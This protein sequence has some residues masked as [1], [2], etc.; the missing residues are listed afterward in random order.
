M[1]KTTSLVASALLVGSSALANAAGF[2]LIE[3]N[4][5]GLGNAYAGA[6][7]VAEDASTVF[8]NPAGM[9]YLPDSQLVIAGHAIRPS[10]EF[11]NGG[12]RTL[13][14]TPFVQPL[15]GG[16][17]GD[18]GSWALVPN[19]YYVHAITP[20]I[21]AG[22]GV[23]AP[24]GLK[25]DY[26]GNWVGRYDAVKS[27]LKTVNIN[28][29]LAWR[30][31]D[32][33]SVGG[34]IDVRYIDVELTSAVD[35]GSACA[36]LSGAIPLLAGCAA[37]QGG[38][39][40]L[41]L[42]GD[43]WGWGYNL[44]VLFEPVAGTRIGLAYRSRIDH[45]L[46]GDATFSGV[47]AQF[48]FVPSLAAATANGP[49]KADVTLPETASLSLFHQASEAWSV[50]GDITWTRWSR[51]RELRVLRGN[52]SLIGATPENWENTMRYSLGASYKYSDAWKFRAGAAYDESPVPDAFR[53]PRV[54]DGDR[55]WLALGANYQVGPSG[56]VDFGYVHI[57]VRDVSVNLSNPV[58]SAAPAV[59]RNLIGS[60]DSGIDILSLQYTHTF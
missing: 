16:D 43:D 15:A 39:G 12:S 59:T 1:K 36:L 56:T 48:G 5:S 29:S 30:V 27:D 21:R 2:A 37:P 4:G 47:P 23:N 53:T 31:N 6:A 41:K 60:Y 22:I 9:T 54:P 51:F 42:E 3:Q 49:I 40:H 32:K 11:S 50:M 8:F 38:D 35:F 10:I 33:L 44:G 25:T 52:G 26:N 17:G 58:T 46:K 14:G 13:I 19:F 7:A 55:W 18:A 34:G 45:H 20:G 28:P 24:F 57:F